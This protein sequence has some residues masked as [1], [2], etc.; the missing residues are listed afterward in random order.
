MYHKT[1]VVIIHI[2]IELFSSITIAYH[3]Y[4]NIRMLLIAYGFRNKIKFKDKFYWAI[5]D[6][7]QDTI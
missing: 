6:R 7:N 2:R 5:L 3:Y 4:F 1:W